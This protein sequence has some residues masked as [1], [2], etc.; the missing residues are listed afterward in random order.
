M[1]IT[2]RLVSVVNILALATLSACSGGD[3]STDEAAPAVPTDEQATAVAT[4]EPTLAATPTPTSPPE[5]PKTA[6]EIDGLRFD[7]ISGA[8]APQATA[9]QGSTLAVGDTLPT[10][11][12][13]YTEAEFMVSGTAG[14]YS[15]PATGPVAPLPESTP[16][17]TRILVR[18]PSDAAS[19]SGR[20]VIE[21]FNTSAGA[22]LDVVWLRS[23]ALLQAQGDVWVGVT[24][25]AASA[26]SLERLDPDRYSSLDLPTND[27]QWDILRQIGGAL[28]QGDPTPLGQL[29]VDYLYMV[30]FSQ[31][32]I[33]V[34]TFAMAFNAATRMED[35][36]AV[37]DG[38]LPA[39][40]SGVV[41]PIQSGTAVIPAF[42]SVPLGPVDVPVIDVE[43]QT[44]VA[45]F[46]GEIS[47]GNVYT[48][49]GHAGVRRDDSDADDD[50]YR[51]YELAGAPHATRIPGCEGTPSDFPTS[52]FIRS[53]L[54]T[55]Q[56]WAEAGQ[57]PPMGARLEL[58][59]QD[60]VSVVALDEVGNA[61]GGVRSPHI[62]VPLFRYDAHSVPGVFCQLSG[63]QTPLAADQ[64]ASRYG[65]VD[66]YLA[67][68]TE[69][70]D[71]A[72]EDGWLLE[73]D[74]ED[75][76]AEQT[77][78]ASTAFAG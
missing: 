8:S 71:Q 32:G 70:L 64:L 24:G 55:L 3:S 52:A 7:P 29:P 44:D 33:D 74:R 66:D 11:D 2:R 26:G 46:L 42:E 39:G 1:T 77:G 17:A 19:F 35:G 78:A 72:I 47:P 56:G 65:S 76:L 6:V 60:A 14:A 48:S 63:T 28:K 49:L 37:Y 16:F 68:F 75:L 38:Y 12:S 62:D 43:T 59:S 20:V 13:T 45:G 30:G 23:H 25:R 9:T 73:R 4:P 67:A 40:H 41:A 50:K 10:L 53:A 21:P 69:S 18:M 36:S 31:S 51:L 58:E 5:P 15:G 54:V 22:D 57:A 61:L 27:I 34:A